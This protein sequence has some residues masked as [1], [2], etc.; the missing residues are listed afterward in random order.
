MTP[1]PAEAAGARHIRTPPKEMHGTAPFN[2]QGTATASGPQFF[3]LRVGR[4]LRL[5]GIGSL[6]EGM[7]FIPSLTAET[8]R[9][10]ALHAIDGAFNAVLGLSVLGL[11]VAQ[12]LL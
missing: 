11:L 4:G 6:N 8:D 10:D 9:I 3:L 2:L 5:Q 7:I 1:D 12:Y